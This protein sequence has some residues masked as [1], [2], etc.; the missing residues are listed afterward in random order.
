MQDRKQS[1]K[2]NDV[3]KLPSTLE[4]L[5]D[6][7][8]ETKKIDSIIEYL[9]E[10]TNDIKFI[11]A[12]LKDS[13]DRNLLYNLVINIIEK[14]ESNTLSSF[15]FVLFVTKNKKNESLYNQFKKIFMNNVKNDFMNLSLF[16][17]LCSDAI[18]NLP[19]LGKIFGSIVGLGTSL[20]GITILSYLVMPDESFNK[21]FYN[22]LID[23]YVKQKVKSYELILN[24]VSPKTPSVRLKQLEQ[25]DYKQ[26]CK[27]FL[28]INKAAREKN[29]GHL[30]AL[31]K[32]KGTMFSLP[33]PIQI[34]ICREAKSSY[35]RI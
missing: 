25:Y 10:Q 4:S 29:E 32:N 28:L 19:I 11:S 2:Y 6:Y 15:P 31:I 27:T 8:F 3:I 34:K 30:G 23:N 12:E 20:L 5:L 22:E 13:R 18:D 35:N 26:S 9:A 17:G 21:L 33:K 24:R 1:E 14:H 7:F 16:L